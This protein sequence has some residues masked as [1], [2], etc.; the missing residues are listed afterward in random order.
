[1]RS[2][3]AWLWQAIVLLLLLVSP[4]LTSEAPAGPQHPLVVC[5]SPCEM[6]GR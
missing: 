3:A 2:L 6:E 4:M 1:M 5:W